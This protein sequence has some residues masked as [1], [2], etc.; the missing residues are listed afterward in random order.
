V[1]QAAKQAAQLQQQLLLLLL[2]QQQQPPAEG[3]QE[4]PAVAGQ[5]DD[6]AVFALRQQRHATWLGRPYELNAHGHMQGR[7]PHWRD[8]GPWLSCLPT[9][10]M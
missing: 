5:D 6:V 9:E 7:F 4:S 8:C 2:Q 10:M 1:L 3:S